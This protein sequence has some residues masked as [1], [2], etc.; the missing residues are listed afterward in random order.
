MPLFLAAL[1]AVRFL[2]ALLYRRPLGPTA[3]RVAGLLQATSLPFIVTAAQIGVDIDV[4]SPVTGAALVLGRAA[5]GARVPADRPRPG[6]APDRPTSTAPPV[7]T[8]FAH[9]PMGTQD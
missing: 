7:P 6:P 8:A 2:P 5:V 9:R 3:A 1:F 4:I